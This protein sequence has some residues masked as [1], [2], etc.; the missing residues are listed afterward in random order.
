MPDPITGPAGDPRAY[1][2]R[3]STPSRVCEIV[4]LVDRVL[5]GEEQRLTAD[6]WV[7]ST[8]CQFMSYEDLAEAIAAKLWPAPTRTPAPPPAPVP[9][10]VVIPP[11]ISG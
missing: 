5:V 9:P 1:M 2:Q 7:P 4:F 3:I 11:I 10:P 8:R 6:G